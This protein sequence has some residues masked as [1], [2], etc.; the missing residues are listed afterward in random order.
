MLGSGALRNIADFDFK[1]LRM[2]EVLYST[3]SVTRTAERLGENQPTVSAWLGRL[4]EQ[5]DD[6]LFVRTSHGMQP[7]VQADALI[8]PARDA[9]RSLERLSEADTKFDPM[10]ARRNF[11]I[12]MS[13][14]SH[15]ALLPQIYAY[16]CKHAPGVTLESMRIDSSTAEA[17]RTGLADIALIGSLEG[18]GAGFY[19]QSLFRQDW[20][21]LTASD[22]P[23]IR[24]VLTLKQ[25]RAERHVRILGGTAQQ[26]LDAA[27]KRNG[28][29]LDIAIAIPGFLGLAG[30]LPNS[31]LVATLPRHIGEIIAEMA[32]LSVHSCPFQVAHVVL[33]QHWHAR[34]H[35]DLGNQWLRG[36]C[37]KLFRRKRL[38][39]T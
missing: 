29:E 32:G 9:I 28:V 6:P 12:S 11:V 30:V 5:F 7:T 10:T 37:E 2:F 35:Y 36:V 19:E 1:L 15:L 23:R 16:T 25:Y 39:G 14:S 3:R 20:I 31:E 33:K 22:H 18:L 21:C 8:E 13:D 27:L 24:D 38:Y 34:Y 26:L 17:L 4:R